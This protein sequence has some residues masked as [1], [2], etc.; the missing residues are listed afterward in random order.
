MSER[1][2][3]QRV[4]G[5]ALAVLAVAAAVPAFAGADTPG[6][7]AP[8]HNP[9]TAEDGWQAGTC[10]TDAPPC[11]PQTPAQFYTQAAGHPQVGLTQF[12]VKNENG[13]LGG[14]TP[15]GDLKTVGVDLPVGLSVTP[16]ATP[17]C[18]LAEGASPSTCPADTA[19][20]TSVLEAA[21]VVLGT[22]Q[23]LALPSVPVY[24][25]VPKT[26]E[27]ARFGFSVLGNDVFLEGGIAWESDYHE[28][29]KI[30][31]PKLELPSIP[32]IEGVRVLRNRL[33]FNGRAGNGSFLTTPS[34]CLNPAVAP[35]QHVYSTFL[36]ADSF[37]DPNPTFPNGSTPFEAPLPPGVMPTGC[38]GG[39][40]A[41]PTA[42]APHINQTDT[43]SRP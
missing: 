33:V 28:F 19:V 39:P 15:V 43:T 21:L 40:F 7:I 41:P 13:A 22:G 18:Q 36:R 26:G 1:S 17:H 29:F 11:S 35:N 9:P 31:V 25:I 14:K 6:I 3:L 30:N 20:G 4:F 16:Q 23:S 2:M 37:Q 5:A 12:I 10:T 27:A 38:P 8:Q 32:G 24:N 42:A 34:T